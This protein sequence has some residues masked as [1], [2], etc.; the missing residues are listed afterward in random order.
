MARTLLTVAMLA[1]LAGTVQADLFNVKCGEKIK[2]PDGMTGGKPYP[3]RG[4]VRF[5]GGNLVVYGRQDNHELYVYSVGFDLGD[6]STHVGFLALDRFLRAHY[7]K[8]KWHEGE[9]VPKSKLQPGVHSVT[10][11]VTKI[12]VGNVRSVMKRYIIFENGEQMFFFTMR[13]ED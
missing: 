6:E 2:N 5:F 13:C 10:R 1:I 3:Q 11:G 7:A 4:P 8:A 12:G 9:A